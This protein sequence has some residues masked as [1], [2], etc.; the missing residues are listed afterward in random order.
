[1][2]KTEE[3]KPIFEP[4]LRKTDG[5]KHYLC[6]G[7]YKELTEEND[8]VRA[9]P[10]NIDGH[11]AYGRACDWCYKQRHLKTVAEIL[12]TASQFDELLEA[13]KRNL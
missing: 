12:G 5:T 6:V 4:T 3:K 2:S 7:C 9:E 1:M 13:K 8:Y 10:M 11:L